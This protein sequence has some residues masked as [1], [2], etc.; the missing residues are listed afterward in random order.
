MASYLTGST[1][2]GD[3]NYHRRMVEFMVKIVLNIQANES[4]LFCWGAYL[5]TFI[6]SKCFTKSLFTQIYIAN[7]K[8]EQ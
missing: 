3:G 7:G 2:T 1:T 8:R 4:H 6:E 5:F